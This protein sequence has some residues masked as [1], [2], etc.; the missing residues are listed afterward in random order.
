MPTDFASVH[1][2]LESAQAELH[3]SDPITLHLREA[4]GTLMDA[5]LRAQYSPQAQGGEVVPF[6]GP[7]QRAASRPNSRHG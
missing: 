7:Q 4:I 5:A 6:P 3:G 1:A 2:H